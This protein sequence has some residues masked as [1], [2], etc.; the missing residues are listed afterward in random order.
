[1][2]AHHQARADGF[3]LAWSLAH[4]P[5]ITMRLSG[6]QIA[7]VGR[8]RK[9]V[10]NDAQRAT[11]SKYARNVPKVIGVESIGEPDCSCCISSAMWTATSEVTIWT[12]RLSRDKDGSKWYYECRLKPGYYTLD[13]EGQMFSGGKPVTWQDFEAAALARKP[14]VFIQLSLPSNPSESLMKRVKEFKAKN[15]FYYRL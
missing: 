8:E 10:L 7:T 14:G 2:L 3:S 9:L 5:N 1:M 12:Q 15:H 11:L 4:D 6:D 13:A